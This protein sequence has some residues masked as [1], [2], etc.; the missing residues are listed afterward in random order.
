M[1]FLLELDRDAFLFLNSLNTSWLD[2]VMPW[3]TRTESWIPLY[4]FL[5]YLVIKD[6]RKNSWAVLLGVALT[7]VLADQVTGHLMKPYFERLRP[8]HDPSLAGLVHI[9]DGYRGGSYGFASGHAA[10]TFGV[11]TFVVVALSGHRWVRWLFLWAALM[12]YSRIYL[13]VH[14]PGDIIVGAMVGIIAALIMLSVTLYLLRRFGRRQL[15]S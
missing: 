2:V 1:D 8:S 13:G 7:I 11:A 6:Y 15:S 9:V 4:V 14:Y 5:I 10:N 12:T 3:I